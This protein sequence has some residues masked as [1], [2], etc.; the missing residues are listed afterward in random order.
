[1]ITE[2]LKLLLR[3]IVLVLVQVVILNN[4]QLGGFVNPYVYVL[5]IL[6]LPVRIPRFLLLLISFL[7][8]ITID[9]FSDTM[10]MHAAACVFL[11]YVRPGVLLLIAPREGY[12]AEANPSLKG[13]GFNWFLLYSTITV[14]LHHLILFYIEV[15]RFNEFLS[16]LSRALLS[17]VATLVV[18][19]IS[20]YLF[21]K[22]GAER[23]R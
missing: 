18:I 2:I 7:T 8:G 3:F 22:E 12:E 10:G 19:M 11:G 15:F 9:I 6:L 1:M 4:I 14:F 17:T 13:M 23:Q 20:Q 21:G 16:T 5:M